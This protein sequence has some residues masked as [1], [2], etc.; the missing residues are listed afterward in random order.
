V[1]Q[2]ILDERRR[3]D[4]SPIAK[5]RL[6]PITITDRDDHDRAIWMITFGELRML[7]P[8]ALPI[9]PKWAHVPRASAGR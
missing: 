3:L 8:V 4:S 6:A 2:R 7:Q 5:R 1:L 9:H